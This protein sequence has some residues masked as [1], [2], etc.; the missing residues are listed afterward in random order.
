MD[1][2]CNLWVE[3]YRPDTVKQIVMPKAFSDYFNKIVETG[4]TPN[5]LLYSSTPGT[6]KTTI[7]KAIVHD[8]NAESL[9]INASSENGIDVL[10]TQIS[11]FAQQKSLNKKLKIV[12]LD[13]ADGL[14]INFQSAL[15]AY[16]EK[17][18]KSCRFIL[19][20]NYISKIIPAL[21]EGRTVTWDFNM[22]KAEF[23]TELIEKIY[24]RVTAILGAEHVEYDENAVKE[25][26]TVHAPS[27]RKILAILQKYSETYGKIDSGVIGFK[28][29]SDELST[30]LCAKKYTDARKFVFEN[31]LSNTDVYKFLFESFINNI[32]KANRANAI[33]V[34]AQY[35]YQSNFSALPDIQLAACFMELMSLL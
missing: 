28:N 4:E 27:L 1:R 6:G 13:E 34:I 8:L 31:G 2:N 32:P 9:Y 35:E 26:V 12:I 17:F 19:T 25:L 11:D 16:I 18:S 23:R 21:Q 22:G 5:L 29:V 10:R 3:K 33:L 20:A 30:L 7:A 15:R 14:T 24:K